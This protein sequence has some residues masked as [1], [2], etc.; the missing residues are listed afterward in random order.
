MTEISNNGHN[1]YLEIST[2]ENVYHFGV[3]LKEFFFRSYREL[4]LPLGLQLYIYS[5]PF[6]RRP[7]WGVM[8]RK[9]WL[10]VGRRLAAGE[11]E[12]LLLTNGM[13]LPGP[14][15]GGPQSAV[16]AL[17]GP[18]GFRHCAG[19][20][21]LSVQRLLIGDRMDF[22]QE[23]LLKIAIDTFKA[24]RAVSGHITIDFIKAGT[25]SPN[26][27]H[28]GLNPDALDAP[29][30]YRNKV[31][32][33]FWGNMLSA[34][35]IEKLGGIDRIMREAPVYRVIKIGDGENGMFLQVTPGIEHVTPEQFDQLRNY[36]KPL[37][38]VKRK[39]EIFKLP[40]LSVIN[41]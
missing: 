14:D 4:L 1:V 18:G 31:C 38:P 34:G 21:E 24:I 9:N 29:W 10:D 2:L 22:F 11:L 6:Y 32:G 3:T 41:D 39:S 16:V 40:G 8:N 17:K 5:K 23:K 19:G 36:L 27:F 7:G 37:L 35:H 20:V 12:E 25:G 26:P 33:C 28:R 13:F 30:N 15:I